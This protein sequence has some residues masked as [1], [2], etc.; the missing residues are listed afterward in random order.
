M[1]V[2]AL[3]IMTLAL[4]VFESTCSSPY[5]PPFVE[6][7]NAGDAGS[8][9]GLLDL[10]Q[11]AS[12][13]SPVKVLWIHGMCTH[14]PIWV[15]DRI[16]R[17]TAAIGGTSRTVGSRP[18]GRDGASMRTELITAPGVTIEVKFFSWSPLTV[19][20]KNALAYDH[21]KDDDAKGEFPYVRSILNRDLKRGLV[22]DCLTDALVYS[23]PNGRT[24]RQAMNEAVC[25]ALGGRVGDRGCD[26][27]AGE[28]PAAL[29]FVTESLGSK[30][31]FDA[32]I[33]NAARIRREDEAG[34]RVAKRLAN[35]KALYM[36]S[37]QVP[38]FD[39]ADATSVPGSALPTIHG[40]AK[41]VFDLLFRARSMAAP[42]AG[43]LTM[44]AF[45]DPNDL[46][47]YRIVPAHLFGDA[48]D[49]RFVNVIVSNDTTYFGYVERPDIAHCGYAWN[50]HVL[51]MIANGY[52]ADKPMHLAPS[53][54]DGTCWKRF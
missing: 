22:N 7:P 41:N 18:V 21:S 28:A 23:G 26:V 3:W 17:L 25:D 40:S 42:D 4:L 45:T 49:F 15:D 37:N 33:W 12:G 35:T 8:F 31:L 24:I 13:S 20:H 16:R 1:R 51:A 11:A 43:P 48:K 39:T 44:I 5:S 46:L 19:A 10:A 6:K 54:S 14:P 50:P 52:Q 2:A 36:V 32:L 27:P 30:L 38:L 53:L 9:D 47:S 34:N 29:A